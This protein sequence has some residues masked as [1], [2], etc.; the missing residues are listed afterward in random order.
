MLNEA[1]GANCSTARSSTTFLDSISGLS[2]VLS[3][4]PLNSK[5]YV[6]YYKAHRY[7]SAAG[8]HALY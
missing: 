8:P 7:Q 5:L 3:V 6:A 4:S 1:N 2:Q